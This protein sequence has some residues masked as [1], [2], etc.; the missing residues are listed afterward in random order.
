MAI[1]VW[2]FRIVAVVACVGAGIM[3]AMWLE[4]R[5]S[6]KTG[7]YEPDWNATRFDVPVG[8]E[9]KDGSIVWKRVGNLPK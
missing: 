8:T 6:G 9:T 2:V 1:L 4:T 3:L 7:L 5:K